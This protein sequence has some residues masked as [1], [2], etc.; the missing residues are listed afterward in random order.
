LV[1][2]WVQALR[3]FSGVH[4][5]GALAVTGT[6]A[7]FALFVWWV[8]LRPKLV[9][10]AEEVVAVNPWGTQRVALADVLAVTPGL[11]GARLHLRAGFWVSSW[12]LADAA[13]AWPTRGRRVHEV[14][15]AIAAAQQQVPRP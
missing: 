5:M 14:A 8:A 3:E 1:A 4:A 11:Y 10:T 12:A 6:A 2:L 13:G 7:V 9:V 15:E